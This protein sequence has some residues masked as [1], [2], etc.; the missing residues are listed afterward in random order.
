[1]HKLTPKVLAQGD[2]RLPASSGASDC[3]PHTQSP[4]KCCH[5]WVN[6]PLQSASLQAHTIALH[7]MVCDGILVM[8]MA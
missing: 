5:H 2:A 3:T 6:R 1:M 7:R 8:G 4:A